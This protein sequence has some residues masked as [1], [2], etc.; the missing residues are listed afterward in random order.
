MSF[1]ENV[2]DN[3]R[4]KEKEAT[5]E[6]LLRDAFNK[7]SIKL[8]NRFMQDISSGNVQ[9]DSVTDLSRLFQ[10]YS[11]INNIDALSGTGTGS[12]PALAPAEKQVLNNKLSIEQT[13]NDDGTASEHI[14]LQDIAN[15]S[16]EDIA[17]LMVQKELELNKRNE[18]LF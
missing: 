11:E 15:L 16:E 6:E 5:S 17:E 2:R 8:I 4:K 7:S 10:I 14:S 3:L 18:E 1:S 12:L 9:L 13:T